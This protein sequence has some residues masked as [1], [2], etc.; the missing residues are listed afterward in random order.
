MIDALETRIDDLQKKLDALTDKYETILREHNKNQS[1]DSTL[2]NARTEPTRD[3][4]TQN[5]SFHMYI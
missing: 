1:I 5:V 4:S 2:L 3:V